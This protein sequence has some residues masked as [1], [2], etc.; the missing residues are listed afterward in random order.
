MKLCSFL[1]LLIAISTLAL[2]SAVS[3]AWSDGGHKVVA[4]IAYSRMD[5]ATRSRIVQVLEQHPLWEKDFAG[6]MPTEVASG[7]ESER[8][9][10]IFAQAAIW[11][12][13]ARK[14]RTPPLDYHRSTWHY[15][16]DPIFIHPDLA[17]PFA[18]H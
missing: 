14:Y 2:T 7:P 1:F 4:L 8:Q 11:P 3:W 6:E 5:E 10:W 13:I 15:I 9:R 16:N 18:G 12:D 17:G